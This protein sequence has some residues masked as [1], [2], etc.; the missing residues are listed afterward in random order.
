L[1]IPCLVGRIRAQG[2]RLAAID[3]R[4]WLDPAA[5]LSED[6]RRFIRAHRSAILAE[7]CAES[8]PELELPAPERVV[9]GATPSSWTLA[10]Q[11]RVGAW[12]AWIGECDAE[13]IAEI[14][15][16]CATD[17]ETRSYFLKRAAEIRVQNSVRCEACGHAIPTEHPALVVCAAGVPAPGTASAWWKTDPHV[18][19][20]F[21]PG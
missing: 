11:D 12:L 14:V 1:T 13:I 19:S 18:C 2:F 3:G 21:Q 16:R 6:Q 4:L 8:P 9:G 17:P 20:R 15:N 5:R 7:L 10:E